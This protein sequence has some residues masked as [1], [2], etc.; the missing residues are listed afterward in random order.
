MRNEWKIAGLAALVTLGAACSDTGARYEPVVDGT[1]NAVYH[2]DLSACQSLARRQPVMDGETGNAVLA[3][4]TL[5]AVLGAAD[6]DGDAG[7]GAVAGALGGLLANAAHTPDER[8]H[9]V[10]ACMQ[11]R[12]HRVVG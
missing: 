1:R 5:G 7:G 2:D 6:D 10:I 3:G 9:M 4:A 12:G 11:Q 8:K